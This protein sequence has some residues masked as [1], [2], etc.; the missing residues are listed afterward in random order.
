MAFFSSV[1]CTQSSSTLTIAP[2]PPTRSAT[3]APTL[4]RASLQVLHLPEL[5]STIGLFL[6]QRDALTCVLVCRTWRHAFEPLVWEHIETANQIP[7]LDLERHAHEIRSLSLAGLVGMDRVLKR[8]TRL[9]TVILW[10]DAFEEEE[11]EADEVEAEDEDELQE[12]DENGEL[13]EEEEGDAQQQDGRDEDEVAGGKCG[14]GLQGDAHGEGSA[15][16]RFGL[17]GRTRSAG[18]SRVETDDD[19]TRT[20]SSD[21]EERD[22]PMGGRETDKE[23]LRRDS[24]VGQDTLETEVA[25]LGIS[26]RA[27]AMVAGSEFLDHHHH[28]QQRQAMAEFWSLGQSSRSTQLLPQGQ[29]RRV[30]YKSSL[31]TL[32][33]QNRNLRR[34]EVYV[35]RKS[36]GGS[37]WRALA[38]SPTSSHCRPTMPSPQRTSHEAHSRRPAFCPCP[39]L[40]AFQSLLNLHVHKH[41]ETFWQMCTRLESL[42]LEGCTL[43]Q[44]DADR[45]GALWFPRLRELKFGK[46]RE[47]SLLSQLQL[48]RQCPELEVLDWRVPRLGFPVDEFCQALE[49]GRWPKLSSLTL[50]E[51]RLT[52]D[53]LARILHGIAVNVV[54]P[55][56][57]SSKAVEIAGQVASPVAIEPGSGCTSSSTSSLWSSASFLPPTTTPGNRLLQCTTLAREPLPSRGL[58]TLAVRRSDFG[59]LAFSAL[60]RHFSTIQ[61]LDLYQCPSL[62]SAMTQEILMSCPSLESFDGHRLL[63]KDVLHGLSGLS[64]R[65][66][67]H[68]SC[69]GA[70]ASGTSGTEWT[71][72]SYH[73]HNHHQNE[74]KDEATVASG[75]V[76]KGLRYLDVHITGFSNADISAC[77]DVEGSYNNSASDG[78]YTPIHK[79][80]E[81]HG[82]VGLDHVQGGMKNLA[83]GQMQWAVFSQL[84]QLHMLVHLSVGGKSTL[85]RTSSTTTVQAG[86][87][88]TPD[89]LSTTLSSTSPSSS[90][91]AAEALLNPAAT[92]LA[93]RGAAGGVRSGGGLDMRLRSGLGQLKTL[94]KLR[95]LRF[96][97]LEQ[98]MEQEDVAWMIEH[99]P[100]LRVVQGRLHSD[101]YLE[102][103]LGARL[104]AGGVSAWT[105]YNQHPL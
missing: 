19:E 31:A 91:P 25:M 17:V 102:A 67:D 2:P 86:T 5:L 64:R 22:A 77:T 83:E 100:E 35:E 73:R 81:G 59:P 6:S 39:R 74:R 20:G 68:P 32:L 9:E 29:P 72:D 56:S 76:C 70:G 88:R 87:T 98:H 57:S 30:V 79:N 21:D 54:S 66:L 93:A 33:L 82:S 60:K 3:S 41:I 42:D 8:C 105:M 92:T 104:E 24:G 58:T 61:S 96:M 38:A 46:I 1:T 34:V 89:V 15:L 65:S 69:S 37:F 55:V 28:Q 27:S 18:S 45:Y 75:W 43:R 44:L 85:G 71:F 63:V 36:P 13:E 7:A 95:M 97:G 78:Y 62:T 52:D 12:E 84:A 47:M 26:E 50:P 94:R 90:S 16:F 10:P 99:L 51:S 40:S 103:A 23:K 4:V 11:D 49:D 14:G 101:E 80:D 53:A 48:M